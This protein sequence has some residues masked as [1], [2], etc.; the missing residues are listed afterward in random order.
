MYAFLKHLM[1]CHPRFN[2]EYKVGHRFTQRSRRHLFKQKIPVSKD[3]TLGGLVV[4][5]NRDYDGSHEFDAMFHYVSNNTSFGYFPKRRLP[6][7]P[8]YLVPR[9]TS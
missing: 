1:L 3:R 8:V 5:L 2:F 6:S 4:T 9:C 7:D